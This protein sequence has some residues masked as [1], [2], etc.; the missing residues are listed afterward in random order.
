MAIL[1]NGTE[2]SCIVRSEVKMQQQLGLKHGGSLRCKVDALAQ[3]L[4]EK[5]ETRK[6]K[7]RLCHYA[8]NVE[9][10]QPNQHEHVDMHI[11]L[12]MISDFYL[13]ESGQL[14]MPFGKLYSMQ[15]IL[16]VKHTESRT[17]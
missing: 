13:H 16:L 14:H 4:I 10:V 6:D 3:T 9:K 17:S 5:E 7:N 12:S 11:M 1:S 15:L 8:F 2:L